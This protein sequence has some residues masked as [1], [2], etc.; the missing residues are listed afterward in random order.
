MKGQDIKHVALQAQAEAKVGCQPSGDCGERRPRLR[1]PCF[2]ALQKV[3]RLR[4]QLH[5]IG[6]AARNKHTVFVGDDRQAEAFSPGQRFSVFAELPDQPAWI[7]THCYSGMGTCFAW[8]LT[9]GQCSL[10]RST[11][12]PLLNCCTAASIGPGNSSCRN[13][14]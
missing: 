12:V 3:E 6:V 13:R 1:L 11:L 2:H 4:S 9:L 5:F 10:Q 7:W 14:R 8:S